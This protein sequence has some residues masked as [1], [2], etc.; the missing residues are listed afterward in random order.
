MNC[1]S[2]KTGRWTKAAGTVLPGAIA[3]LLPKCP[4][5]IA[6]WI[7][8]GTGVAVPAML[9]GSVRPLLAMVCVASVLLF[10]RRWRVI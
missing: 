7:A 5:C 10:V 9:A 4:L 1:C 8:A 6:A 2:N 3:I